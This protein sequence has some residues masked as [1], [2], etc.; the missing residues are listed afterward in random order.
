GL[1]ASRGSGRDRGWRQ[2]CGGT[3]L[4]GTCERGRG[5]THCDGRRLPRV[6]RVRPWP[7]GQA[8]RAR[9]VPTGHH[10]R[11]GEDDVRGRRLG[12]ETGR[13]D[14]GEPRTVHEVRDR[15]LRCMLPR[16]QARVRRR[17]DLHWG[18][19]SGVRGLRPFP[20]GQE[21]STD[22]RVTGPATRL[23]T[24]ARWPRRCPTRKWRLSE[25][26]SSIGTSDRI[27]FSPPTSESTT[28]ITCCRKAPMRPRSRNA[29]G[30]RNFSERWRRSIGR[31]SPPRSAW[32]GASSGTRSEEHTSEL[33]S[34]C[35]LV[36]RLLL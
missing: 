19:A 36:C 14:S 18:T 10:V 34:P 31:L 1:L 13:A 33:Q 16:R 11:A 26:T 3:P 27:R 15:D 25:K 6:P 21:R 23:N 35:N 28:A 8:A 2:E 17:I 24:L 32:T 5:G 12:P 20:P 22:P 4:R 7:G 30:S 29:S 9:V